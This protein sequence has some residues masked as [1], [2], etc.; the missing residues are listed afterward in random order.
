MYENNCFLFFKNYFLSAHQNDPKHQK[1]NFKQ[2]VFQKKKNA[3]SIA[4]TNTSYVIDMTFIFLI[5]I[6][7]T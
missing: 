7:S 1:F 5:T 2:I 3:V 4:K 6:S